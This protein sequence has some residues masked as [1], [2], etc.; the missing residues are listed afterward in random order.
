[1]NPIIVHTLAQILQL[2]F[3]D[4]TPT[5]GAVCF[6]TNAELRD[7]FK[8]QFTAMDVMHYVYGIVSEMHLTDTATLKP[9]TTLLIPYPSTAAVFWKYCALGNDYLSYTPAVALEIKKVSKINWY[10]KASKP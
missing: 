1:M 8:I 3:Y 4:G 2:P 7:E 9:T 10:I 6:A 5:D